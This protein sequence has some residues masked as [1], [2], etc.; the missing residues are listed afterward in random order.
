MTGTKG[1]NNPRLK[2]GNIINIQKME[3]ISVSISNVFE[4]LF[5]QSIRTFKRVISICS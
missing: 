3:V 2:G 4:G 5:Q 1:P